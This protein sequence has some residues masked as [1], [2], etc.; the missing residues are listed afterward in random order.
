MVTIVTTSNLYSYNRLLSVLHC[1]Y[2]VLYCHYLNYRSETITV[3]IYIYIYIYKYK[4]I[5]K[6]VKDLISSASSFT[7]PIAKSDF[8][9][10]IIIYIYIHK[11]IT[12]H[13]ERGVSY[14]DEFL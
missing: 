14:I 7:Q 10:I 12:V 3:Y 13:D 8:I 6:W 4:Y 5:H 1:R 11:V 9:I 2:T